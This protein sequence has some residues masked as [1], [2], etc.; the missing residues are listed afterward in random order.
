MCLWSWFQVLASEHCPLSFYDHDPA[1]AVKLTKQVSRKQRRKWVLKLIP[2][3]WDFFWSR[4]HLVSTFTYMPIYVMAQVQ[5]TATF[6]KEES[7]FVDTHGHHL[8][9]VLPELGE[10]GIYWWM[11]LIHITYLSCAV[12]CACCCFVS[13]EVLA[14]L[15]ACLF[16]FVC[17]CVWHDSATT[18]DVFTFNIPINDSATETETERRGVGTEQSKKE[19]GKGNRINWMAALD[20]FSC[21]SAHQLP[22]HPQVEAEHF[23]AS[24]KEYVGRWDWR[25]G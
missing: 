20:Y 18:R 3:G 4:L 25:R 21:R 1:L 11:L 13:S 16:L 6:R 8:I 7:N 17:A 23:G 22:I 5:N 19:E 24:M 10:E 2:S 12:R 14:E 9:R 15:T